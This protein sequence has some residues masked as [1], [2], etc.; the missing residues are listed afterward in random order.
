[1]FK[2]R[3]PRKNW[4]SQL[5]PGATFHEKGTFPDS[6]GGRE[7]KAEKKKISWGDNKVRSLSKKRGMRISSIQKKSV[8]SAEKRK[9]GKKE[10]GR[11]PG[12][13]GERG[14]HICQECLRAV[15]K[16]ELSSLKGAKKSGV[17]KKEETGTGSN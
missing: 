3:S 6:G 12:I 9:K 8:L 17:S 10:R 5:K 4:V 16:G 15:Q 11:G 2:T 7:K 1:L 14:G 13:R